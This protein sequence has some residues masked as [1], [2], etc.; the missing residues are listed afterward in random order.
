[1]PWSE[2]GLWAKD[3]YDVIFSVSI[4]ISIASVLAFV[5]GEYQDIISFFFAQKIFK[6]KSFF[7]RSTI[8]NFWSQLLDTLIFMF[9]AF[10]GVYSVRTILLM[11]LPWWLYKVAMGIA[12]TPLSYLGIY[13]LKP[14]TYENPSVKNQSL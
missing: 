8:S 9:V 1:M 13:F 3:S 12:Y 5:I 14:K 2:S 4:R 7:L 6:V 10:S 11:S